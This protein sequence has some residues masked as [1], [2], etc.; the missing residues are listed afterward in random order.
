MKCDG[1]PI[2]VVSAGIDVTP[3]QTYKD[4]ISRIDNN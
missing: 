4:S 2:M 1:R 3:D